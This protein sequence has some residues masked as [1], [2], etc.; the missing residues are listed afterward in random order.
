MARAKPKPDLPPEVKTFITWLTVECGFAKN[1]IAAYTRDLVDLINDFKPTPILTL[2]PRQLSEHL[3]R[4]K[5]DHDLSASSVNRHLAT[6]KVFYRHMTTRGLIANS[7]AEILDPP[8]RWKRLPNVLSPRQVQT[9]V[10]SPAPRVVVRKRKGKEEQKE[11]PLNLHLRDR[12]LL[13]LLYACGL[14]ASEVCSLD[15]GSVNVKERMLTVIGKGN[16]QRIVP[17]AQACA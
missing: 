15:F 9:L 7:P 11:D 5:T 4:L 3:A 1:T 8:T 12:A 14:R 6:L 17:V 13:D 16:K 2:S 10:E